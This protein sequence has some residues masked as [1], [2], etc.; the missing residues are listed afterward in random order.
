MI[1]RFVTTIVVA[2]CLA[3]PLHASAVKKPRVTPGPYN[4]LFVSGCDNIAEGLYTRDLM[5]LKQKGK[6]VDAKY[7]KAFYT[8]DGCS[9]EALLVT[10]HLPAVTWTIEDKVKIDG[11]AVDRITSSTAAGEITVTAGQ[12]DK[13]KETPTDWLLTIGTEQLPIQKK[14]EALVQKDLRQVRQNRLLLGDPDPLGP[15][16]Y[17]E[18]LLRNHP[19]ERKKK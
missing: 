1:H 9:R 4:G 10:M 8:A 5:T 17:P 16:G 13:V 2:G 12:A 7:D 6:Q 19:Y 15:D 14:T 11:E 18:A 3:L